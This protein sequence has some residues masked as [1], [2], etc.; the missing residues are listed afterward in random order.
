[1]TRPRRVQNVQHNKV[2]PLAVGGT[3]VL[4]GAPG[5]AYAGFDVDHIG[6]VPPVTYSLIGSWPAGLGVNPSNGIV[7][8][9][10]SVPGTYTGLSVRATDLSGHTADLASFSLTVT[11]PL[12]VS[13]TPVISGHQNDAY[14]G[15]TVT[16][17]GGTMP[18]TY[19]LVGTWPTGI[20]VNSATGAVSGTPTNYGNFT[21]LSV[22]VTDGTGQTADLS[23]FSLAITAAAATD[24][25]FSS[26]KLLLGFDGTD[27]QTTTVDESPVAHPVTLHRVATQGKLSTTGPKFGTASLLLGGNSDYAQV[28]YHA[29]WDFGGALT[30]FTIE[31]WLKPA[32]GFSA[33]EGFI[34]QWGSSTNNQSWAFYLNGGLLFFRFMTPSVS[35]VDT[36]SSATW[37]PTIGTWYHLAV[38]RDITGKIRLYID[39]VMVGSSSSTQQIRNVVVSTDLYIGVI[40]TNPAFDVN[41]N[42]DEL[43]ITKGVARYA[44]DSG[45]TVPTA[46]FPRS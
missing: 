42:I 24:P 16:G 19:S 22:R 2:W 38:D 7:S 20:T 33:N 23:P 26:V 1:M 21:G 10:P 28:P 27:G 17:T 8:G 30:Q 9:T 40:N 45:Y 5:T 14:A 32:T 4:T 46:A 44:S 41:G 29:D 37:T 36:Q 43:R 11:A 3:P 35:Y 18:L 25:Y 6:G 13:G 15:F 12:S 31:M 39:G 34:D